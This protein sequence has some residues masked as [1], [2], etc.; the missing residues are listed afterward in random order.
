LQHIPNVREFTFDDTERNYPGRSVILPDFSHLQ[1]LEVL[2]IKTNVLV[3]AP[4]AN[5]L[6]LRSLDLE[7][8]GLPG[9]TAVC[10]YPLLRQLRMKTAWERP[11]DLL[12]AHLGN[13]SRVLPDTPSMLTS[14][15]LCSAR[16]DLPYSGSDVLMH[17]RL[18]DVEELVLDGG[19]AID[20][21][22]REI[23]KLGKCPPLYIQSI[24]VTDFSR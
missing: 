5:P 23:P 2:R 11:L 21:D 20:I 22:D 9:M 4:N 13:Q 16:V 24:H 1:H 12:D 10:G 7:T 15:E 17:P 3:G 19:P 6:S 8:Q 18:R 14:L